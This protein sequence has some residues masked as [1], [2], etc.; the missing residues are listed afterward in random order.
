MTRCYFRLEKKKKKS[1]CCALQLVNS[2]PVNRPQ[3]VK[4]S[5]AGAEVSVARPLME[6]QCDGG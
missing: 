3:R 5:D 1:L 4:V 2:S 6:I